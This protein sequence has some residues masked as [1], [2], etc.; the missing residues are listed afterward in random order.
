MV[1]E[2]VDI[3]PDSSWQKTGKRKF[4]P[5]LKPACSKATVELCHDIDVCSF[6]ISGPIFFFFNLGYWIT[7]LNYEAVVHYIHSS[8]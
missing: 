1:E 8:L 6:Y 7:Y 4:L 2:P 3:M 5:V